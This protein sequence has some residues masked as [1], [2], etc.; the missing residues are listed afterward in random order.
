MI[1]KLVA[2]QARK[3]FNQRN[4]SVISNNTWRIFNHETK[5]N[6]DIL[7]NFSISFAVVYFP[8]SGIFRVSYETYIDRI[9]RDMLYEIADPAFP[10][11]MFRD[12]KE[13]VESEFRA[14]Y[15]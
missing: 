2:Q 5:T 6:Q 15:H 9:L 8:E 3:W 10:E 14:R 11:N 7:T 13:T 4:P 1:T 12:I